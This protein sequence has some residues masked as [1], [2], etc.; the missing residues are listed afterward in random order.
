MEM[1]RETLSKNDGKEGRP[2]LVAVDGKVYD[3]TGNRLW[4]N[5]AHMN[6]HQAGSDLTEA[7]AA[8]PHGKDVLSKIQQKGLLIK[9]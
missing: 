6:R 7:I 8:S 3:V 5:G 1:D 2:A 9:E 4:K